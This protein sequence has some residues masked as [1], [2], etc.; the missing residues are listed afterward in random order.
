MNAEWMLSGKFLQYHPT[1]ATRVLQ[2]VGSENA[3]AYLAE[4]D[5][6][7]AA[8]ALGNMETVSAAECLAGCTDER[9]VSLLELLPLAKVAR[10]LHV[11]SVSDRDRVMKLAPEARA[12]VLREILN[13]PEG[14]AATRMDSE[15]PA[16]FEDSKAGRIWKR[17]S[18]YK[19]R[20]GPYIYVI[21][22]EGKLVGVM[23]LRELMT[24]PPKAELRSV[25]MSPVARIEARDS[26]RAVV[27]HP[28]WQRYSALPVVDAAGV[29]LGVIRY[30][31]FRSMETGDVTR[32]PETWSS[33][34][35]LAELYW[36]SSSTFLVGLLTT[37]GS[38]SAQ[39]T[40][41]EA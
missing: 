2:A 37:M 13:F 36:R 34:V 3:A 14:S 4:V 41:E 18:R 20:L 39:P 32:K 33:A 1:D 8:T 19:R 23:S 40:K 27:S 6:K 9:I 25:M 15:V 35:A 26:D 30:A 17:L 5:S 31:T 38:R 11:M 7:V 12:R 29:L 22:A 16:F 28:G 21:E 10:I 24:A